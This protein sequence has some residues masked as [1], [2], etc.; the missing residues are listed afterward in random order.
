MASPQTSSIQFA[1]PRCAKQLRVRQDFAGKNVQCPSCQGV[2]QVPATDP[3]AITQPIPQLNT[4]Q[5][6]LRPSTVRVPTASQQPPPR[7]PTRIISPSSKS[8]TAIASGT[9]KPTSASQAVKSSASRI[10][11]KLSA[12]RAQPQ[13]AKEPLPRKKKIMLIAGGGG[14]LA[15]IIGLILFFSHQSSKEK[16]NLLRDKEAIKEQKT[17]DAEKARLEQAENALA[18]ILRYEQL[19]PVDFKG[20]LK[21][22]NDKEESFKETP[23][24]DKV[25]VKRE[26][27]TA[28]ID[29]LSAVK[30][31]DKSFSK[32]PT[33]YETPM[34]A[35]EKL[36]SDAQ[37]TKNPD[38]LVDEID[39]Y[40]GRLNDAKQKELDKVIEELG[41]KIDAELS[42]N[43][44]KNALALCGQ[45]PAHL[46]NLTEAKEEMNKWKEKIKTAEAA[47]HDK[48]KQW[49][50]LFDGSGTTGWK[51]ENCS[52]Y[53]EEDCLVITNDK[54]NTVG[55]ALA[56]EAN[57]KNYQLEMDFKMVQ[58]AVTLFVR[59]NP[60]NPNVGIPV[61]LVRKFG[62]AWEKL[63]LEIK[64][65]QLTYTQGNDPTKTASIPDEAPTQGSILF[66]IKSGDKIMI[67]NIRVKQ[68]E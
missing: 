36:K 13:Q 48:R 1:C 11:S 28:K 25:K 62:D 27:L 54:P 47:Y 29:I 14:A 38:A 66:Y 58:G 31:A 4:P 61:P 33:D 40:I 68:V 22:L 3:A 51:N 17:Q 46:K 26:D 10:S 35:Y 53:I 21:K 16:E 65:D 44:F 49:Q 50:S 23:T 5:P 9:A 41:A 64:D 8:I 32:N 55:Y 45:L 2:I 59:V 60:S 52:I 20:I 15:V 34:N 18:E 6:P 7:P 57:W 67:K 30:D 42:K 24:A 39:K 63:S 43:G 37:A 56:G 19:A 12:V